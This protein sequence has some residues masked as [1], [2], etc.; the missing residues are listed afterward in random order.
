L[1][2]I[3]D[4]EPDNALYLGT[5]IHTGLEKDVDAALESYASNYYMLTTEHYN[6]MIKLEQLIPKCKA[7]LPEGEHEIKIESNGYIGYIDLLAK[8]WIIDFKYSNNWDNYLNSP[9]I[10][11]Y[12]F[13]ADRPINRL[14]YLFIPKI[15]IRQGKHETIQEFR[16]RLYNELE[17]ATPKLVDVP[18]DER[19]VKEWLQ[20]VKDAESATEFPKNETRLCRWCSYY[21]YCL[22]GQN[23]T[24]FKK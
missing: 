8:D 19:K 24:V 11:L 13:F 12:K 1:D 14:S 2:V 21:D 6:E 17:H 9:Q 4:Q 18:Y 23:W 7:L 15:R 20:G 16:I 10:H 22:K 5:A 3:P